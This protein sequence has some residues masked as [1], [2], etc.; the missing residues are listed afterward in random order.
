MSLKLDITLRCTCSP[1]WNGSGVSAPV[2]SLSQTIV[3]LRPLVQ[4]TGTNNCFIVYCL[5]VDHHKMCYELAQTRFLP[6]FERKQLAPPK[7][8]H[9]LLLTRTTAESGPCV[10]VACLRPTSQRQRRRIWCDNRSLYTSISI[11]S[12]RKKWKT[13]QSNKQSDGEMRSLLAHFP[14]L[15]PHCYDTVTCV[16]TIATHTDKS[17]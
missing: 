16:V 2:V 1:N 13:T 5:Y 9:H 15:V 3:Q 6:S 4:N 12:Q 7:F 17:V 11:T 8:R 14:P 10:C